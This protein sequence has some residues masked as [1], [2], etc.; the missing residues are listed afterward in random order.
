MLT[1]FSSSIFLSVAKT[2]KTQNYSFW[3]WKTQYHGDYNLH[4][5]WIVTRSHHTLV[6]LYRYSS[7]GAPPHFYH[8]YLVRYL[9][10]EYRGESSNNSS[11]NQTFYPNTSYHCHVFENLSLLIP[12]FRLDGKRQNPIIMDRSQAINQ[13][14]ASERVS[15]SD[16]GNVPTT[17]DLTPQYPYY[18]QKVLAHSRENS[19]WVE[20]R[21]RKY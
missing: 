18:Y 3:D 19:E 1:T 16:L 11:L 2:W 9:L 17:N 10:F 12:R 20:Q 15:S 6:K 21:I 13:S 8:F 14:H 5:D 4:R 7:I